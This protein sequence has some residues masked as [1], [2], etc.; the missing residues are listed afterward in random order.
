MMINPNMA[1]LEFKQLEFRETT[2]IQGFIYLY[3]IYDV[4]NFILFNYKKKTPTE[5]KYENIYLDIHH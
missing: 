4:W 3:Y 2:A 5:N 1:D